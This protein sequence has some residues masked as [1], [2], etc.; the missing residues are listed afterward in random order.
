VSSVLVW[1]LTS[2]SED[3]RTRAKECMDRAA[4]AIDPEVKRQFQAP[5]NIGSK[6]RNRWTG[7]GD[8]PARYWP[9]VLGKPTID[10]LIGWLP[11][12]G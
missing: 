12:I 4:E 7:L 6:W 5:Q 2:K 10:E 1:S 9:R 11:A 8:R 3:Y